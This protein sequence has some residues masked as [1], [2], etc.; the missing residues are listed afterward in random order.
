MDINLTWTNLNT[1]SFTTNIYRGTAPL[2]RN[3]LAN[4][5]ASLTNGES[6]F[7][8][9]GLTRDVVYYFVFETVIGNSKVSSQNIP[10]RA[11]P[12]KGPGPS[13]LQFGDFTFGY[14]GTLTSGEFINGADLRIA[15]GFT[16][17]VLTQGGPVWHKFIRNSKTCYV[18]NGPICG[19]V[20]WKML[21]DLGLV[22]GVDGPG[23]SNAG[24]NINQNVILTIN[25]ERFRVRLMTGVSDNLT[26]YPATGSVTE[27]PD[28]FPNEWRD[29]VYPLS[30]YT[31]D[32]QRMVNLQQG[33][34]ADLSMNVT[35]TTGGSLIQDRAAAGNTANSF[36]RGNSGATRS[37]ISA[38]NSVGYTAAAYGWWPVLELVQS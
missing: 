27:A 10:I 18:P 14:Y 35:G 11:V 15:C 20:S 6:A 13:T 3:A 28:L 30:M 9:T 23:I 31:P 38:R 36:S 19:N 26:D 32:G 25:S 2:D 33:T 1:G 34:P 37:G 29:F 17:G 16:A 4:P 7:T 12:R 24:A 21:Y 22:Y 5:I 8:A